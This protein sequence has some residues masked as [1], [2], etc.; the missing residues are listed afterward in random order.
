MNNQ[1]VLSHCNCLPEQNLFFRDIDSVFYYIKNMIACLHVYIS[2]LSIKYKVYYFVL[3]MTA[4]YKHLKG[5]VRFVKEI[6]KSPNGKILRRVMK[7]KA[8]PP[9]RI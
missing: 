6:P 4:P 7:E 3:G 8:W 2:M 5:G 1:I 9:S